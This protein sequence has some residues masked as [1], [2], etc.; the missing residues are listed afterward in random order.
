MLDR[1]PRAECKRNH[2]TLLIKNIPYTAKEA[3]L[4]ELFERYGQL[5]RFMISPFNTLAIAEYTSK[6]FAKAALKNLS[7]HK[8]NFINPIYLEYAPKGFIVKKTKKED[9]EGVEE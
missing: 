7:Y 8:V 4:K 3:E 1:I 9:D 6:S 2:Y 5:K